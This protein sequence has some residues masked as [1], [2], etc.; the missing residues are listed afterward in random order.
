MRTICLVLSSRSE[1]LGG[2][3]S[4]L[5]RRLR[6]STSSGLAL[7][8]QQVTALF[9]VTALETDPA[10][11]TPGNN[12]ITHLI[13]ASGDTHTVYVEGHY[14]A[15]SNQL[16]FVIQSKALTEDTAVA[17]DTPLARATRMYV[18]EGSSVPTG[19]VYAR[20]GAGGTNMCMIEAGETQSQH[21]AT[22]V[23]Y[24]D[25]WII[26]NYGSAV[27]GANSADV[28]FKLEVRPWTTTA[29][30]PITNPLWRPVTRRWLLADKGRAEFPQET[31][32]IVGPNTDVRITAL[33][34]A[35]CAVT[36]H[37]DGYLAQ[38][39]A[40]YNIRNNPYADPAAV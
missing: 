18:T 6:F 37:I 7:L 15:S 25:F 17:L 1:G 14:W 13:G 10:L 8:S 29:G 4:L 39:N 32:I 22:S 3:K 30:V 9:P 20:I 40:Y 16:V 12:T 28:E 34:D 11:P 38:D 23:S 24:K 19:P 2:R 5:K 26:T 27:I 31:P 36:A 35:N 21:C 33:T